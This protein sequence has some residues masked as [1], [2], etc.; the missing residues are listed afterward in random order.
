MY[1]AH[2]P[3]GRYMLRESCRDG[4]LLR[5]RDLF[6][7]GSNPGQFLVYPGGNSFYV[8]EAVEESL[9]AQDAL[10]TSQEV[11]YLFLP[12]LRPDLRRTLASFAGRGGG[13]GRKPLSQIEEEAIN[14][15]HLFDKRRHYFLRCGNI[16]QTS[17]F[18]VTPRLF[19]DLPGKSRDELEQFFLHAERTLPADQ[20]KLYLYVIFNLQQHFTE[21]I[22]RTLPEGLDP[23]QMD[24]A[25]LNEL[26]RLNDDQAFWSGFARGGAL[27]W[28]LARYVWLYFDSGFDSHRGEQEYIR[29][30]MDSHRQFRW[31]EPKAGADDARLVELFGVEARELRKMSRRELTRLFR[32]KAHQHHPDKGGEHDFFVE[33]TA[34]Y[35]DLLLKKK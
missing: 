34:A 15:A 12:F 28:Y 5:N 19:R 21:M 9:R 2:L 24:E 4:N 25:F 3:T 32:E 17:I 14:Q 13:K 22:A 16:N 10:F 26:C 33:L 31:P 6:D 1:L 23:G 18:G 27:P 7:L 30:F 29:R 8:N 11:E 35:D 20:I